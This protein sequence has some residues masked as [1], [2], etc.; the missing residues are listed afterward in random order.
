MPLIEVKCKNCGSSLH[1]DSNT[2]TGVCPF[3]NTQYFSED[4]VN[5]YNIGQANIHIDNNAIVE[6]LL[7]MQKQ[8]FLYLKIMKNQP[9]Y[10]KKLL[11]LHLII[12]KGG[13]ALLELKQENFTIS[14]VLHSIN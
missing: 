13:G 2:K 9:N 8:I 14:T 7:K 3:C 1:I 12:I 6:N 4:T 5:N 10:L 11:S